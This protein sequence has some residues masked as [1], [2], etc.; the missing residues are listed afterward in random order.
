MWISVHSR[1]WPVIINKHQ[2]ARCERTRKRS[3]VHHWKANNAIGGLTICESFHSSSFRS[4]VSLDVQVYSRRSNIIA[5]DREVILGHVICYA[6][7]V[8]RLLMRK[9]HSTNENWFY[10]WMLGCWI[11]CNKSIVKPYH[12][13][14]SQ[15]IFQI[16]FH[17]WGEFTSCPP[18]PT[19]IASFQN[20]NLLMRCDF[21]R[22]FQRSAAIWCDD[23]A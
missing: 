19:L 16:S 13:K 15:I 1:L 23:D 18:P 3:K 12:I 2:A 20:H 17:S 11:V 6:F 8:R 14:S 22:E 9:T 5:T 7:I 21:Q 10:V 4:S